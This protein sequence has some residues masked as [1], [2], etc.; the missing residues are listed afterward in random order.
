MCAGSAPVERRTST[1]R[2]AAGDVVRT[3]A[4][5][6]SAMA[7]G[8]R[9]S[10]ATLASSVRRGFADRLQHVRG[11]RKN[12]FLEIGGVGDRSVECGHPANRRVEVLEQ[13]ARDP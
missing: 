5:S 8:D 11:L 2:R 1:F 4:M 9:F 7:A 13:I 3:T 10:N 6:R 12:D